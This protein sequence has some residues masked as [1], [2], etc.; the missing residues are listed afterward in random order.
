[1]GWERK[2]GVK[3]FSRA[4][5]QTEM[6]F[7]ELWKTGRRAVMVMTN[8]DGEGGPTVIAEQLSRSKHEAQ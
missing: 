1:M 2:K 5:R 7:T 8:E 3:G 6:P 4:V